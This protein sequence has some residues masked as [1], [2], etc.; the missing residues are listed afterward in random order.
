MFY[1]FKAAFWL[2]LVFLL[3]PDNSPPSATGR[4]ALPSAESLASAAVEGAA[5]LC[6]AN[7]ET[8][9]HAAGAIGEAAQRELVRAVVAPPQAAHP[10]P[11]RPAEPADARRGNLTPADLAVPF[12]GVAAPAGSAPRR[13]P[14]PPRRPA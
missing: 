3:L 1:L 5:S 2:G 4:P 8:C 6:R 9:T 10:D 11:A 13:A 7:A 14:L 12:G